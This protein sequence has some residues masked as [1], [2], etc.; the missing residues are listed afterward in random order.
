[1]VGPRTVSALPVAV[2]A[3]GAPLIAVSPAAGGGGYDHAHDPS[4][5]SRGGWPKQDP[6]WEAATAT[7]SWLAGMLRLL[8]GRQERGGRVTYSR[9]PDDFISLDTYSVGVAHWWAGTAPSKLFAPLATRFSL[10]ADAAWGAEGADILRDPR[11]L[12]KATGDKRGHMRFHPGLRWLLDGWW[13]V[14]R[15]PHWLAA[16]VEVWASD[17]IGEA[18][19]VARGAGVRWGELGGADRGRVLAAIARMCNSSPAM[20]RAV[21]RRFWGGRGDL[22]RALREGYSVERTAGGYSKNGNGPRRWAQIEAMC[23]VEPDAAV[24]DGRW[25]E[26]VAQGIN[27]NAAPE[28]ARGV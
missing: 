3:E 14:A 1:M 28:R 22:V 10:E 2:A 15:R 7:G 19:E 5:P 25:S 13:Q 8:T 12:V 9:G 27:T 20:A 16:Q 18:L 4:D 26:A 23:A 17:Y 11:A 24:F 6:Q 21:V